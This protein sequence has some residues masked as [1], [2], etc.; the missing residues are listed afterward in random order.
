M[1]SLRNQERKKVYQLLLLFIF[2]GVA[3]LVFMPGSLIWQI[4]STLAVLWFLV[5]IYYEKPDVSRIKKAFLIGLFLMLFDFLVENSGKVLGLWEGYQSLQFI[6]FVPIEVVILCFFGGTA[7][8]LYLPKK[9][10]IDYTVYDIV[11]FSTFGALGEFILIKNGILAYM[12]CWTSLHAA[13]GY[14]ITW[15]ILHLLNYKILK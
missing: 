11:I 13:I 10:N 1:K 4:L 7:W 8:S 5:E 6:L 2:L 14:A 9:F 3:F 12:N 15:I